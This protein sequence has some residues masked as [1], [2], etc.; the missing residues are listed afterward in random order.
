MSKL[1]IIGAI[2]AAIL[3]PIVI[4]IVW[5]IGINNTIITLDEKCNVEL[6]EIDNMLKRRADLLPNLVSTVKGYAKHEKEIFTDI[7][8]SR[9]KLGG[10]KSVKDKSMASSMMNSALSRLLV[11]VE[12]Y[13]DLKANTNFLR[14]QDELNGTE[15]RIAVARTRYNK[16]VEAFNAY[17]RKF[18]NSLLAG[19]QN[20]QRKDFFE[21]ENPEDKEVPKVDFDK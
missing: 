21:I 14:L 1:A 6:S 5:A 10:A 13:P 3:V 12:R 20:A 17:I 7:A 16:S 9:A 2:L 11:V 18:P 8:E 15:N 19:F 4:I